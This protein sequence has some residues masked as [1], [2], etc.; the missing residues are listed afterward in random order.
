MV[1][2]YRPLTLTDAL[3]IRSQVKTIILAGGSDLMIRHR[4]WSGVVPEYL[5]PVLLI[6]HLRELQGIRLQDNHLQ[7][8][9]ACTLAQILNDKQVPGFVKLPFSQMASPGI[10]NLGTLGGNICNTSPAADTLPLLYALE[11][12]LTLQGK[13]GVR[14]VN[15]ADFIS[16]P[17]Q[18]SLQADEILCQITLPLPPYSHYAYRKVGARRANTIS[19]LSFLALADV[20]SGVIRDLRIAL[21]AVA[22]VVVRSPEAEKLL[23]GSQCS[24]IPQLR[25]DILDSYA[26]LLRPLDDLR[27]S[28]EYRRTVALRLLDNFLTKELQRSCAE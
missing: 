22:P 2:I 11:A 5:D 3:N 19:K 6:G 23:I 12:R 15:I 10:R 1:E 8:G 28:K 24:Q 14:K 26:R 9:A 7:I 13:A 25:E 17:G 4:V 16:G 21:G 20:D 27:S 18:N